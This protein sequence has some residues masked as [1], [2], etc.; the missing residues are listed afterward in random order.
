MSFHWH[1]K[2]TPGFIAAFHLTWITESLL[3]ATARGYVGSFPWHW[4]SALG[5]LVRG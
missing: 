1:L 2:R 5:S 4:C 3:M